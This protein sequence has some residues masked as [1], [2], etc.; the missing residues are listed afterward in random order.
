MQQ[1][2]QKKPFVVVMEDEDGKRRNVKVKALDAD[3]AGVRAEKF[4]PNLKV[5]ETREA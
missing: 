5:V 1:K 3:T 4:Q 2:S